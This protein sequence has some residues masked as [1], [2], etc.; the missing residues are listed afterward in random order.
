LGLLGLALIG[1]GLWGHNIAAGP[2]EWS[3]WESNQ[4]LVEAVQIRE[5]E[6]GTSP[7]ILGSGYK[8][9]E[10]AMY[11]R[12][13]RGG[14]FAEIAQRIEGRQFEYLLLELSM[15]NSFWVTDGALKEFGWEITDSGELITDEVGPKW[16]DAALSELRIIMKIE[17][18]LG[19]LYL[20]GWE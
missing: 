4:F 3:N 15:S 5:S 11:L 6:G 20:L 16:I 19:Y 7:V 1:V 2:I 14:R 17:T 13:F 10:R 9:F 12:L 8:G 18:P